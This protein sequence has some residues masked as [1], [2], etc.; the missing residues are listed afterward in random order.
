MK[1]V[2]CSAGNTDTGTWSLSLSSNKLASFQ[3][4]GTLTQVEPRR[5]L[6]REVHTKTTSC[7]LFLSADGRTLVEEC[8]ADGIHG[9][10]DKVNACLTPPASDGLCLN[11]LHKVR[12]S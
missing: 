8:Y 11:T 1:P 3:Q 9:W 7:P 2:R 12:R 10:T 6:S 4:K 5:S